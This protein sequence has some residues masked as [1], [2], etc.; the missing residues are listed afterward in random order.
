MLLLST[1]VLQRFC[2]TEVFV[3]S[4]V[5]HSLL[6]GTYIGS[7]AKPFLREF[8]CRV[9]KALGKILLPFV[10]CFRPECVEH[11]VDMVG[12]DE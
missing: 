11:I 12:A 1:P 2:R 3:G 4:N 5:P 10:R 9:G 8:C 7:Y 6:T